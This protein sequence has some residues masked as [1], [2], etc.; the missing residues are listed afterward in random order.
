MSRQWGHG[1]HRGLADAQTKNGTIVGLW[2]LSKENEK[3]KWQGRV[4]RVLD[5]GQYVVQLL[6]WVD[7]N[8]TAK[9]IIPLDDMNQWDFFQT[10]RDMRYASL[11]ENGGTDEDF[12]FSE[13]IRE[14]I[15]GK[16][17][18]PANKRARK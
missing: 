7:G 12:Q 4:E 17:E 18:P 13:E 11:R 6:S 15:Y 1:F 9:K 8:P 5:N 14:M 2:F 3:T 16:K 10:S